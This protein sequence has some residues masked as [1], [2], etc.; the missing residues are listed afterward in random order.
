MSH[1]ADKVHVGHNHC[2]G[3]EECLDRLGELSPPGIARVHG[4][5]C[6]A[7]GRVVEYDVLIFECEARA[8]APAIDLIV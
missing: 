4:D 2:A 5:I 3:A 6:R 1:L 8:L 7:K